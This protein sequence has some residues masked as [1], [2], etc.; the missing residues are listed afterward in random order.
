MTHQGA[1]C[2]GVHNCEACSTTETCFVIHSLRL[3]PVDNHLSDA[4]ASK[5]LLSDG[6]IQRPTLY[7]ALVRLTPSARLAFFSDSKV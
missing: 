7:P 1:P 2:K 3:H 6:V 5:A 4:D